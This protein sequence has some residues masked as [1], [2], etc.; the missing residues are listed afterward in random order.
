V[1]LWA[2]VLVTLN[3]WG[4]K[5]VL[6]AVS[7]AVCLGCAGEPRRLAPREPPPRLM[8]RVVMPSAALQP[9]HGRVVLDAS[10][11]PM[12][13]AAKYDPSFV[14]PGGPVEQGRSGELC[15]TP[16]V[17]DLPVGRYR[18]FFSAAG[19][20]DPAA[21]DTDDFMVVEGTQVYRRAPGRYNSPSPMDAVGPAAVVLLAC[22]ALA[23]GA[24]LSAQEDSR[25]AG[26]ALMVGGA[27]GGTFGGIWAYNASRAT[28]QDGA[29]ITFIP[30]P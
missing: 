23:A 10:D 1:V 20:T 4:Y 28:Q 3:R 13:V 6:G 2:M 7:S 25:A 18:L 9:R 21:G 11:G 29:S 15:V 5:L 17:V 16:C 26:A 12:R 19:G 14:P 27:V 22:A 24:A 8:P 30:Q